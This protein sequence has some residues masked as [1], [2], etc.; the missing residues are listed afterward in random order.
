MKGLWLTVLTAAL[1]AGLALGA[2]SPDW[3]ALVERA[4]HPPTLLFTERSLADART[5]IEVDPDARAWWKTFRRSVDARRAK[6]PAIPPVGAQWYHWYAC[7][8]CGVR[9]VGETPRRH[10]CAKCKTVYS[11][12]PYDDSYYFPV[13][14]AVDQLVHDAAIAW[15]LT[16]DRRY[17]ACARD[18]LLAYAKVY[19]G[20]PRHDNSGV[21][22]KNKDAGRAFSQILD[23]S[24]WLINLV[25]GYDAISMTLAEEERR[26]IVE[27]LIRPAADLIHARDVSKRPIRGNHQCWHLSAYALAALVLGDVARLRESMEGLSGCAY[28]LRTGILADGFWYEGAWGYHFYTMLSLMPY[29]TALGNLGVPPP[30]RFKAMFDAP[31]GVRTPDGHLP[32]LNDSG[33]VGFAPGSNAV[34]YEQAWTWWKDPQYARWLAVRPR[35]TLQAAL[36]GSPLP[37]KLAPEEPRSVNYPASGVAVLR[38]K[39]NY[40]LMDYGPHGGW[41]GHYDK[42]NLLVWGSGEMF[43]EDPGCVGYGTPVHWGWYRKSLAHNTLSVDGNQ[44]AAD[45]RLLAFDA[46]GDCPYVLAEAGAIA[47]GVRVRRGTALKDDIVFD[48]VEASSDEEHLYE[49]AFHSRGQLA[50]SVKGRPVAL[51]RPE[52][53]CKNAQD[54]QRKAPQTDPWSWTTAC[55]EGEHDGSWKAVWTLESGNALAL[56]QRAPAGSLRTATGGAQPPSQSFRL[57]VNRVRGRTI[58]FM[59]VLLL[60]DQAKTT[61]VRLEDRTDGF[62]AMVGDRTYVIRIAPDW[63]ALHHQVIQRTGAL[64][65]Q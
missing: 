51:T 47:K 48:M 54:A 25:Q 31:F 23:E 5:R 39:R 32:A 14:H 50:A 36:Y 22:E 13:H 1:A 2:E 37:P 16:G 33:R 53:V 55:C 34:Y 27:K 19:L 7:P 8:T 49:W 4:K 6:P 45:G 65:G 40:V 21:T 9:L 60:G 12:W 38:Q 3:A 59:T 11:G 26:E 56:V 46:A 10:V 24:V 17:A 15:S 58:R 52:I 30:V 29:F 43:A 42:L 41:H 35:T 61:D 57:A 63:S 20:Y 64:Q 18:L 62:R 44:A 28:Q